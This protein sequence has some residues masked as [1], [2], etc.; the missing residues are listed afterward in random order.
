M[1]GMDIETFENLL[2]MMTPYI[3][4]E[5]SHLRPYVTARERLHIT[6]RYL[7]TGI[8]WRHV[9]YGV[10]THALVCCLYC[11]RIATV[12]TKKHNMS[13]FLEN[14][15]QKNSRTR[16]PVHRAVYRP[17][18]TARVIRLCVSAFSYSRIS[19]SVGAG[20]CMYDVVVKKSLRSL[21][22]LLMS[23]FFITTRQERCTV[24]GYALVY[25]G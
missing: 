6:L 12:L 5:D 8:G 10:K 4:K 15:R 3:D 16:F 2:C 22:H 11:D 7:A 1:F 18:N 13:N 14:F 17:Y 9:S 20:L 21:S 24:L 23:S 25:C 19:G